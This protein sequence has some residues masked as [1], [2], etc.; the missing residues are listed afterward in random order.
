VGT[1]S[2]GDGNILPL[3]EEL[4]KAGLRRPFMGSLYRVHA[5]SGKGA[6]P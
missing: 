6:V 4:V 5:G 3:A 1:V 2:S